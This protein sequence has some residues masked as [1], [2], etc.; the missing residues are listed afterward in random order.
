MGGKRFI[1]YILPMSVVT[2]FAPSPT[3]HLHLGH[4]YAALLTHDIACERSGRFLLRIEDID[5]GRCRPE[6]ADAIEED[7][8][9]LGI[10]WDGGVRKQSAHF[11]DYCA[12]LAR[13]ENL[14]VIYPCFCTRAAIRAELDSSIA[15]P[16]GLSGPAYPGTCRGLSAHER[17]ERHRQGLSYAL[18]LD[19]AKAKAMTG[20]LFWL[21]E[22]QGPVEAVPMLQG[23]IVLAR[24]DAPTSYHLAVTVD[25][26]LQGVTLVT[27]GEDLFT[28]TDIHRLLQALLGYPTPRYRHHKILTDASGRRFA[29][30]DQSTTLRGLRASGKTPKQVRAMAGFN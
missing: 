23:D 13:L 2:R 12:A 26:A 6:Y 7:L 1:D 20:R 22:L 3:G 27:R 9:W 14:D 18:R 4:A 10:V 5:T 30:R 17:R 16:H 28:A 21:D 24:K 25:D 19:V 29:K 15:A 11:D 8:S